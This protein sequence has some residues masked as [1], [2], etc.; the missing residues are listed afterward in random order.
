MVDKMYLF[1]IHLHAVRYLPKHQKDNLIDLIGK[2]NYDCFLNK[3]TNTLDERLM[4]RV[5]LDIIVSILSRAEFY[6]ESMGNT[7][8]Q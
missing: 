8:L 2:V 5:C 4:S 7:I 6:H 3:T 1:L